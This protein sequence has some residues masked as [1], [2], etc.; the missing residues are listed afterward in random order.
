MV[1]LKV[2]CLVVERG[3]RRVI[4]GLSFAADPGEA[5]AVTGPNGVGKSTLLRAVAGLTAVVGGCI[6]LSQWPERRQSAMHLVGHREAIKPQHSLLDNLAFWCRFLAAE[7]PAD[8]VEATVEAALDAVGLVHLADAPAELLSQGQRRRL[9][10]ARL[11]V[12]PRPLWLLDEPTAG[13]DTASRARLAGLLARHLDGG[14]LLLAATH[15][16]IGVPTRALALAA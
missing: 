11:L 4:D 15:E 5:V 1:S 8:G 12:A 2:D 13:L 9:A 7:P 10:L 14:G 6:T 16:E 3:G